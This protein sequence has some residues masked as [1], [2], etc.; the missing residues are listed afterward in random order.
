MTFDTWSR[1]VN[2][3]KRSSSLDHIYTNSPEIITELAPIV[4]VIGDHK[5]IT[6]NV[7]RI[8]KNKSEILKRNWCNYHKDKLILR[9]KNEIFVTNLDC[10]QQTWNLFEH[11]MINVIVP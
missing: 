2:G 11:A 3:S 6:F 5:L 10:V 7:P 4:K 9:L 8:I 1:F